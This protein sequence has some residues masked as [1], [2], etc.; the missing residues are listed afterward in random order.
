M[1]AAVYRAPEVVEM[2]QKRVSEDKDLL[3]NPLDCGTQK[4]RNPQG[5][6]ETRED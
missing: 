2:A 6:K 1:C 4:G 3:T 5:H